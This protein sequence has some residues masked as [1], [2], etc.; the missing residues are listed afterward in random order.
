MRPLKIA[1]L[2]G[3]QGSSL[4]VRCYTPLTWLESQ[5]AIEIV[6]AFRAWEAEIVLLHGQWQP[7]ALAMGSS[8]KRQGIRVVADLDEDIFA[9]P[10]EHPS[11][12]A[13]RDA[14]FQARVRQLLGAVDAV[15]VPTAYLAAKLA[16]CSSRVVVTPN[17]IDLEKWRTVKPKAPGRVRVIGFA[18]NASQGANLEVLRPALAKLSNKFRE[19]EIR[20]V[21]FGFRPSWLSGVVPGADVVPACNP[22]RYPLS[23]ATL[24]FDIGLAPLSNSE[25]NKSRSALKFWEYSAGG[26]VTVA[27]NLGPYAS[28]ILNGSTGLLVDNQPESWVQA[29]GKLIRNHDLR[30]QLQESARLSAEAQDVSQTAPAMLQALEATEPNRGRGLFAFPRPQTEARAD[31]DVVIPIHDSSE[32]TKQAIKAA[33]PELDATHRLILV[34]ASPEPAVGSLLNE[35]TDRPWVTFHCSGQNHGFAG[36]CNLAVQELTRPDADVILMKADTRPMRG[37]ARRLAAT[38]GSDP[39]IGTVS[40]VSNE[41][42]IATVPDLQDAQELAALEHPPVLSPVACG[43]LFYIKREVIRKYGL[44]DTASALDGGEEVDLSLRISGEYANVIDP[45]CWAWRANSHAAGDVKSKLGADFSTLIEQRYPRFGLE[46]AAF[47]ARHPLVDHRMKMVAN[48]RDPRPLVLHI[49]HH[50]GRGHGIG[51]HVRDLGAALSGQFLS[52]EAAAQEALRPELR[53]RC[54]D[55]LMNTWPYSHPGWPQT[56]A[57]VPANDAPWDSLLYALRPKL[58]HLHH[59]KNHALSLLAELTGT[60]VPV[61]VSLHDFYFLCPDL[62][63]YNCPGVH[64]CDTCF[65]DRF[66]GPAE[67]QRLRRALFHASL[68]Q[69][70]AIVAPSQAAADLVREVYPDLKIQVIPHGTSTPPQLVRKPGAKTRFGMLGNID[71]ATGIDIILHAWSLIGRANGGEFHLHG[72]SDPVYFRRYGN[73]GIHYHGPY[74]EGDLPEILSQIDVGLLPSQAPEAFSYSLSEFLAAGIPVIGSNCGELSERIENG[75]NG[76]KIAKEDAQA[77]ASALSLLIRNGALREKLGQGVRPPQSIDDMAA[78]YADLY[79]EVIDDAQRRAAG[80]FSAS[81]TELAA[82]GTK[83]EGTEHEQLLP[84][85]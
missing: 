79:R 52:L 13:Y 18:G 25:F 81:L 69:T 39:S 65:P 38:A 35:Y 15:L 4:Q 82:L 31:V 12:G 21:C 30:R 14:V 26:A 63:L 53:L 40:A 23:L 29:I 80:S 78:L 54:G 42:G 76:L 36:A 73:L 16:R 44:F 11:A 34:G 49:L 3:R 83:Q 33:L 48:T 17:G 58:I 41:G 70:A 50:P 1:I 67:Y 22:E 55:I 68:K 56:A 59:L 8:L 37:F 51:R 72:V 61:I 66:K 46:M 19:Q 5:R 7:S 74:R 43:F 32:L 24:G 75:V 47:H 28:T 62:E 2:H 6:P 60:G 27:S 57:Q 20:F 71:A 84:A 10:A 9:A 64:S 85:P 77:W 45:G